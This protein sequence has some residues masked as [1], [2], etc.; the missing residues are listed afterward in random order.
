MK[1]LP[2]P[3]DV[4]RLEL[5]AWVGEDEFGS[6]EVG[7]KQGVTAAG[8]IPLVACKEGKIDR[9]VVKEQLQHQANVY[10]KPLRLCRFVFVQEMETIYPE[11]KNEYAP[12]TNG[13]RKDPVPE[14]GS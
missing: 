4:V 9:D 13:Q 6:G 14:H 11:P 1:K 7:L 3:D 12:R 2:T 5:Y 8:V 10:G